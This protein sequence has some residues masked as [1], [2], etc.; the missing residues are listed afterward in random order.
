MTGHSNCLEQCPVC[1]ATNAI[2]IVYGFPGSEMIELAEQGEV[3][4]GGCVIGADAPVWRCR[5]CGGEWGRIGDAA[6]GRSSK[7]GSMQR[8]SGARDNRQHWVWVTTPEYY[9]NPD[10][11][12]RRDL[13]PSRR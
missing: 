5:E 4:L 13:K 3:A 12:D 9:A 2:P 6:T 10:G 7:E 8:K 1:W 11:A